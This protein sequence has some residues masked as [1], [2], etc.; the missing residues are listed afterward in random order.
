MLPVFIAGVPP[1][2]S[3]G[4][5]AV[6]Q[7]GRVEDRPIF[8]EQV[9][10]PE[11]DYELLVAESYR[12]TRVRLVI[13][14][15]GFLPKEYDAEIT[16]F[17]LFRAI[18]MEP[19]RNFSGDANEHAS[20]WNTAAEFEAAQIRMLRAY[21]D[22]VLEVKRVRL[23]AQ[24][25]ERLD[26]VRATLTADMQERDRAFRRQK[27]ELEAELAAIRA[28]PRSAERSI[29]QAILQR[30]DEIL[31]R[32]PA[33]RDATNEILARYDSA[34]PNDV[35]T[36]EFVAQLRTLSDGLDDYIAVLEAEP[37]EREAE[38]A[39]ISLFEKV[40][41][42][43]E[44]FEKTSTG[45]K[46][47]RLAACSALLGLATMAAP[48]IAPW[49]TFPIM[50]ACVFPG[51]TGKAVSLFKILSSRASTLFQGSQSDSDDPAEPDD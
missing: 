6:S 36:Q 3:V 14:P 19:D 40:L 12:N 31:G 9:P 41:S 20:D 7:D 13:R 4:L 39:G 30:R 48:I 23:D 34:I 44:A 25:E 26:E 50:T 16:D 46:V 47:I 42:C 5:Y 11:H 2:V 22:R 33:L 17:G 10:G 45:D 43:I 38:A 8:F 49:V 28:E 29:G 35:P 51:E 15:A 37:S 1:G 18:E 32:A 27:E 21:A 24:L